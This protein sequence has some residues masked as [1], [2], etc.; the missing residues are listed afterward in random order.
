MDVA[1]SAFSDQ[2]AE[3]ATFFEGLSLIAGS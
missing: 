3:I 1:I 2:L